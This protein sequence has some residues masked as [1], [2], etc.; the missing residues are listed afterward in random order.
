M[1]LEREMES[2]RI[3][4]LAKEYIYR[5]TDTETQEENAESDF[6]LAS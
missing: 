2:G 3:D 5:Y 4:E 6:A 1:F